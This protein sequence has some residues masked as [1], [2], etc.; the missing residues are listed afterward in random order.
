MVS[1]VTVNTT[2]VRLV[3]WINLIN[4]MTYIVCFFWYSSVGIH[5]TRY[6]FMFFTV[7]LGQVL[8]DPC[9]IATVQV[10]F[11]GIKHDAM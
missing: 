3:Y 10:Y 6:I 2:L 1:W 4:Y 11:V 5:S 9:L 7:M 8:K